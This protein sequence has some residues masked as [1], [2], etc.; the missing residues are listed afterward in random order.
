MRHVIIS[1]GGT[2]SNFL[3][4]LFGKDKLTA[5][6]LGAF[7][8][9]QRTAS[10]IKGNKIMYLGGHP[11][12]IIMSAERRGFFKYPN[13]VRNIGGD[14]NRF[15]LYNINSLEK[16]IDVGVN[17]FDFGGHFLGWKPYIDKII[18]YDWLDNEG[19]SLGLKE[20]VTY[21][22]KQGYKVQNRQEIRGRKSHKWQ[23][24]DPTYLM[25]LEKIHKEDIQIYNEY[26]KELI[27]D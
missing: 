17:L 23:D 21:L 27:Y 20:A 14:V 16:Y 24:L 8:P 13:H 11:L 4:H 12:N 2:G 7:N 22:Q 9:H 26:I 1:P 5:N 15:M 3:Y 18:D 6:L 19:K 10:K 25:Q